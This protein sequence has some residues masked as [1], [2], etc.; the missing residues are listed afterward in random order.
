MPGVMHRAI[1]LW[2]PSWVLTSPGAL[3]QT[4]CG[5][6]P[7]PGPFFPEPPLPH[8]PVHTG[9]GARVRTQHRERCLQGSAKGFSKSEPEAS[10]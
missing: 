8:G 7:S 5:P 10:S 2:A 1:R 4:Q 6:L 9:A 3:G